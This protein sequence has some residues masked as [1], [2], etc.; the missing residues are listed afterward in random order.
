MTTVVTVSYSIQ[1]KPNIPSNSTDNETVLPVDIFLTMSWPIEDAKNNVSFISDEDWS[2]AMAQGKKNLSDLEIVGK[3]V[4]QVDI[5]SPSYRHQKII[6]P[7]PKARNLTKLGH[8]IEFAAKHAFGKNLRTSNGT[9]CRKPNST[10]T[11]DLQRCL[12]K[13][14][15]NEFQ[16]Y[17][18]YNGTCNNLNNPDLFGVAYT[19]FR[20]MLSPVYADGIS[21]PRVAV[22][23]KPLPSART[24]SNVVHKAFNRNDQKFTVMLAVWGQ[25]LDHDITATTSSQGPN[26]S[27][28]ACCNS[29]KLH[30]ECFPVVVDRHDPF[31]EHNVTCLEFVRSSPCPTCCLGP[32]EQM[33]QVTAFIDGSVV[34]GTDEEVV[35]KLRTMKDGMLRMYVTKDNRTLLPISE[36]PRDGCNRLE[37]K[38]KGRYCFLAGMV[39]IFIPL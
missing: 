4:H 23:G 38:K 29:K 15:C 7:M 22:D 12:T 28:I 13:S 5:N 9:V 21:F 30:P 8:L 16:K 32:R 36:D 35:C 20:R 18:S 10:I 6:S 34:Y 17:R 2:E 31:Y 39:C 1:Y 25:F 27:T 24:V 11:F 33:N 3:K 26:G 14:S 37:E 19:P